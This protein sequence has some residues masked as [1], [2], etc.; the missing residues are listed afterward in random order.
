MRRT[1]RTRSIL[2]RTRSVVMR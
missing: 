1:A 2:F